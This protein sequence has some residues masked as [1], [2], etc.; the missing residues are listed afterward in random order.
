MQP[1]SVSE[2]IKQGKSRKLKPAW[3]SKQKLEVCC[4][5]LDIQKSAVTLRSIHTFGYLLEGH[6]LIDMKIDDPGKIILS[7]SCNSQCCQIIFGYGLIIRKKVECLKCKRMFENAF[8]FT[9]M[10]NSISLYW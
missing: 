5:Q 4:Y 6:D 1:T 3:R 8:E 2:S 7:L 9:G 10:E